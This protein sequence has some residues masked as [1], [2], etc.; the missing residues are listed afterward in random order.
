MVSDPLQ[1]QFLD[2]AIPEGLVSALHPTFGLRR[3]GVNRFHIQRS[4]GYLEKPQRD[5]GLGEGI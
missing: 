5:G 2:E 3:M 4:K 1:T